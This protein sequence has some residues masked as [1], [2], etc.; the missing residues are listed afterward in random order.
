MTP[1]PLKGIKE[2]ME[3]L[4]KEINDMSSPPNK[5][6]NEGYNLAFRQAVEAVLERIKKR[7]AGLIK[8]HEDRI[9]WWVECIR[10]VDIRNKVLIDNILIMIE[11][12]YCAIN[13]IE[14]WL[15][16]VI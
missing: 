11:D 7:V 13:A 1:E 3:I 14:H 4:L 9:E 12:E 16:D 10:T 8:F 2:E 15:E 6:Y 5:L